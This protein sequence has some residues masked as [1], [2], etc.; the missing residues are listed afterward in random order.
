[1]PN[2]D[3]KNQQF[4]VKDNVK[5]Y[6]NDNDMV[7]YEY[8]NKVKSELSNKSNKTDEDNLAL[9][10]IDNSLNKQISAVDRPKRII[11][12]T[13]GQGKKKGGNAYKDTHEKDKDNADP[14]RVRIPKI[15]GSVSRQ[16]MTNKIQYESENIKSLNALNEELQLMKYLIEYMD[17]NKKIK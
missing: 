14:T 10:W 3:L 11:M 4:K 8:L 12:Q 5:H 9:Q 7:S 17:N 6:F 2:L 13:D 1:M 16:I 15:K